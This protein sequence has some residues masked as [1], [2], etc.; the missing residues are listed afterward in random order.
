MTKRTAFFLALVA[1]FAAGP[2]PAQ[3]FSTSSGTYS[4]RPLYSVSSEMDLRLAASDAERA[5]T[6]LLADIGTMES[7]RGS[8]AQAVGS[9]AP[10]R[11]AEQAALDQAVAAFKALDTKY[12]E[13]LAAFQQ[14]QND[15]EAEVQRQRAEA[16]PLQQLPSAQR[17][18]AAIE[19]LNKWAADLAVRRDT[20]VGE[21][22]RLMKDHARVEAER[23][24]IA[25]MHAEAEA[26]LTS[27]RDSSVGSV[28]QA[29]AKLAQAYADLKKGTTYLEEVRAKLS[30]VSKIGP[31]PSPVLEQATQRLRVFEAQRAKR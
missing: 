21:R 5:L 25:K 8:A 3:Q 2:V 18:Y 14:K 10:K 16:E 26:R 7:A 31:G 28:G 11:Q 15:L 24:R 29:D 9:I 13:D 19:R 20:F 1:A 4:L 23:A 12:R 30:T 22:D 17:D 27:L 6:A